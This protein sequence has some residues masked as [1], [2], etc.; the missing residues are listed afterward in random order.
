[1]WWNDYL[2]IPFVE[3]GR[4]RAGAD[5]WGLVRMVYRDILSV[6]LPDY[7]GIYETTLDADEI[8]D[9]IKSESSAHWKKVTEEKEFDVIIL[10][11]RGLPMHVGIVTKVGKMLH[12]SK[13][14]GTVHEPY[15][16]MRWNG[17]VMGF[18]RW[19]R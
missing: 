10:R 16:N 19:N 18:E 11:M 17:R 15:R 12:C 1:M 3:K 2:T 8:A 4:S 13:D 6:D 9:C 5:C 14:I 7:L